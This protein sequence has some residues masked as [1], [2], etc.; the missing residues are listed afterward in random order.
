MNSRIVAALVS[1]MDS[2]TSFPGTGHW[3]TEI[4]Y[5]ITYMM[6]RVDPEKVVPTK[7]Q[8]ESE[9]DLKAIRTGKKGQ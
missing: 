3:F 1:M 8:K 4:P 9:A 7:S 6:V 5:H 2:I